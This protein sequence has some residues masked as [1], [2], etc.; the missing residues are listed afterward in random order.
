MGDAVIGVSHKNLQKLDEIK[1]EDTSSSAASD[2][3]VDNY[4]SVSSII[5]VAEF[6]VFVNEELWIV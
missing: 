6:Y 4:P 5:R 1:I 3:S 2:L